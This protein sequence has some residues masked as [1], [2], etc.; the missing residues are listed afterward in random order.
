MP[1]YGILESDSKI[2][3][4]EGDIFGKWKR[5]GRR[6]ELESVRLLVPVHPPNVLAIGL[7]YRDHAAEGGQRIPTAP[8]LFL[9]ASTAV[10]GADQPIVLPA[11]A[12]DEVD[13]EA[14]LVIVI[15]RLA[16]N[17]TEDHALDCVLGYTCGND[18]SA[19]DCQLRIDRQWARAKSFD[20]F[21]PLGPWIETKL[22]PDAC[23]I[24]CRLNGETMQ[25]SNTRNL[26]FNCRKLVSYLSRS[27]TLLPG[28]IIMTGTPAG[29]GFARKPPV[30]L[31]PGDMVEV[32]VEG[33][34][35]LRNPVVT[36][37]RIR[38][39]STALPYNSH[40]IVGGKAR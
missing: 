5:S 39:D 15:G 34:G 33:I 18:V 17:V 7:N 40:G 28:S 4:I 6:I 24:R 22:N 8:I 10:V 30:F 13:Y 20:T 11:V 32:E 31:R 27:M 19:R 38:S 9:K 37:D 2:L 36:E 35:I 16:R 25:N 3:R 14:E 12:P 21:A 1:S 26:V 23:A 29:V